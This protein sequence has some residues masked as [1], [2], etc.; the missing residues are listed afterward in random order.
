MSLVLDFQRKPTE[1]KDLTSIENL[2]LRGCCEWV[3]D[4][5]LDELSVSGHVRNAAFFRCWRL[6]DRGLSCFLSRN[7][8]NLQRLE[9]S[10]CTQL[11]DATLHSI[12]RFSPGL[13]ELDLTRCLGITDVGINFISSRTLESLLL[14]A[15]SQLTSSAYKAIACCEG[16]RTLDLCGHCNLDTLHMIR[17]LEACGDKLEYLN[18]SWCT[19][20]TDE[21]IDY[22]IS[23]NKLHR[24]KYLSLFGLKNMSKVDALVRYFENV[25][26]LTEFDIRGIPCAFIHSQNDCAQLREQLP[27]LTEWKLHH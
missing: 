27:R 25:P 16:L 10:G 6:T 14:Y 7:G 9:L 17:I 23:R 22:I 26:S 1:F 19:E 2:S 12:S 13:V 20:L 15:D 5:V 24:I 3:T 4:D 18:L 21:F 8:K 11:T